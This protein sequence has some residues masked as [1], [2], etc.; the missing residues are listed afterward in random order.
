M[1]V[2]MY[3][4]NLYCYCVYTP[5]DLVVLRV[6]SRTREFRTLPDDL[7]DGIEEISFCRD[8][9]SGSNGKHARLDNQ[10][11]PTYWERVSLPL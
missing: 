8:F 7:F 4:H 1:L 3:H 11:G 2:T 9:S 6:Q 10:R 5:I